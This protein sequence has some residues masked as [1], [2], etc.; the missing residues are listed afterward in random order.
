M[1]D[2]E[3][4]REI[5]LEEVDEAIASNRRRT[6][7]GRGIWAALTVLLVI[8]AILLA[9]T[10]YLYTPILV[11]GGSMAPTLADGDVV[12]VAR[13]E[14]AA[15]GDVICLYYGDRTIV[16]RYIAGPGKQVE[17]D[18]DGM[19]YVD[20]EKQEEPYLAAAALGKSDIEYPFETPSGCCFVMGD[21]RALSLDSRSRAFGCVNELQIAGKVVYRLWPLGSAGRVE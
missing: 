17:I 6:R 9:V 12:L 2:E 4:K 7:W 15:P 14:I 10:S 3:R 19:V 5:T 16:K 13:K 11:S 18:G 20:G 1:G 21:D 8:A